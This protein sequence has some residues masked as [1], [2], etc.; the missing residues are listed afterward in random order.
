MTKQTL[1]RFSFLF[2]FEGTSGKEVLRLKRRFLK[3]SDS[4]AFFAKRE[5]MRKKLRMVS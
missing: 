2:S 5:A 4:S 3:E 1:E